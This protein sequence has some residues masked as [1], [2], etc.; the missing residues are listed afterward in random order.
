V[1]ARNI[2]QYEIQ[3]GRGNRCELWIEVNAGLGGSLVVIPT[4]YLSIGR[5]SL[6]GVNAGYLSDKWN[7]DG[8]RIDTSLLELIAE[9]CNYVGS[10]GPLEGG[11]EIAEPA[12]WR[13][14][15]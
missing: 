14:L 4:H 6:Y 1:S 5:L 10:E 15:S 13:R 12:N 2:V 11:W 3:D 7:R 9:A 8:R